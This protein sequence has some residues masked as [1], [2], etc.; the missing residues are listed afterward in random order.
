VRGTV[1]VVK[2]AH[3][4]STRP[5]LWGLR[6]ADRR[7]HVLANAFAPILVIATVCWGTLSSSRPP[8][9]FLGLGTPPPT[10]T[11]GAMLRAGG[12]QE[13]RDGAVSRESFRLCGDQHRGA[14]AFNMLGDAL[15]QPSGSPRC[16]AP[17][18]DLYAAM[19]L[20]REAFR[21]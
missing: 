19:S 4:S 17:S 7:A 13:S 21:Q 3:V 18:D 15:R 9:I 6:T 12:P 5:R 8:E 10:P 14:R 2:A 1:L 20:T 11:W 16:E